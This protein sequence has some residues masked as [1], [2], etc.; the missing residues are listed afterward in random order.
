MGT[1]GLIVYTLFSLLLPKQYRPTKDSKIPF[2]IQLSITSA[3]AYAFD[4]AARRAMVSSG[5]DW[6]YT[7]SKDAFVRILRADGWMAFFRGAGVAM[8]GYYVF[9]NLQLFFK[10]QD[11]IPTNKA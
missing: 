7:S 10:K 8:V 2:M 6:K 11:L 3:T 1:V 9:V 5:E 4:T